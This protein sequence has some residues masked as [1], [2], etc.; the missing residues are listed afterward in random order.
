MRGRE[1]VFHDFQTPWCKFAINLL[2][3]HVS[4]NYLESSYPEITK[5]VIGRQCSKYHFFY[6]GTALVTKEN[7]LVS[8]IMLDKYHFIRMHGPAT[9]FT[10]NGNL[11]TSSTSVRITTVDFKTRELVLPRINFDLSSKKKIDAKLRNIQLLG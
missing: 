10:V 8:D 6:N 4:A 9:H 1:L 5:I 11:T 3:N 7:L 2:D